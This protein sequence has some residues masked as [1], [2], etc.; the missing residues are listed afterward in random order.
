MEAGYHGGCRWGGA[1]AKPISGNTSQGRAGPWALPPGGHRGPIVP[2]AKDGA[3]DEG[4]ECVCVFCGVMDDAGAA[5]TG[6]Y[7]G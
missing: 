7:V 5:Q 6:L 3:P 2:G 4:A 1:G